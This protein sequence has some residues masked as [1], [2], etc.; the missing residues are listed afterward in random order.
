MTLERLLAELMRA[1]KYAQIDSDFAR[2]C[3]VVELAKGR[4]PAEALKAAKRQLHQA[5][6]M[7]Q[8][9]PPQYAA[10]LTSLRAAAPP[11]RPTLCAQMLACHASTWERLPTQAEFYAT[12]LADL[13]SI[14]SVLDLGCGLH[15]LSLPWQPLPELERYHAIDLYPELADFLPAALPLL[16]VTP[17]QTHYHTLDLTLNVPSEPVDLVYALKLLPVLEQLQPGSALRLLLGLPARYLLV[18][19]PLRSVGGHHKGMAHHYQ[20][21]FAALEQA[22][23]QNAQRWQTQVFTF[24]NELVFR[25]EK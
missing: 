24:P 10:W 11:D 18:S 7:Y 2:Q 8:R 16:R 19:Y 6:A 20:A 17:L 21:Q 23:Q 12:C 13:P 1:A 9:Q 3:L 22:A 5:V 4:K 25:I 15:P 14:R